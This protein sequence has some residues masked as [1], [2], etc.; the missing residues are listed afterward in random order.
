[1]TK[2]MWRNCFFNARFSY[3]VLYDQEDHYPWKFGTA[4]IEKKYILIAM[5]GL[6]M[7]PD[8]IFINWNKMNG[9]IANGYQSFFIAFTYDMDKTYV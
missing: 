4:A 9:A 7:N 3:Q 5:F 2:C 1:M 8:L 6:C